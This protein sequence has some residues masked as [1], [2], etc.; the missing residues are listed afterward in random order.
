MSNQYFN[1]CYIMVV[2]DGTTKAKMQI[3]PIDHEHS[4]PIHEVATALADAVFNHEK[5][6][7][8]WGGSPKSSV[9]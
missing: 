8:G 9:L 6:T 7:Y 2:V 4:S 1:N 3:G 5:N